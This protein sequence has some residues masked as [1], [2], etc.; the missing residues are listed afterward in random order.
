MALSLKISFPIA[1]VFTLVLSV[2]KAGASNLR[3]NNS[4]SWAIEILGNEAGAVNRGTSAN[5]PEPPEILQNYCV[6]H[7]YIENKAFS[8]KRRGFV[9]VAPARIDGANRIC[10]IDDFPKAY[11]EVVRGANVS[12]AIIAYESLVRVQ[13]KCAISYRSGEACSQVRFGYE[14][15]RLGGRGLSSISY[16]SSDKLPWAFKYCARGNFIFGGDCKLA[17]IH[18]SDDHEIDGIS[19]DDIYN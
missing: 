11:F 7:G 17:S 6:I 14:V 12:D 19:I 15:G 16:L 5:V 18:V 9:A 13:E 10:T 1:L 2:V 4:P 3:D 8:A